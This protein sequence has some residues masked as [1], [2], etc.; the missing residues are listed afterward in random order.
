MT[1]ISRTVKGKMPQVKGALF[2]GDN[3]VLM[4]D[5]RLGKNVNIWLNCSI[6]AD[7]ASI[8]IGDN[9]NV[10]DNSVIH[11]SNC[12][13]EDYTKNPKGHVIIGKNTTIGH[14]CIIHACRIGNDCLIGMGSIIADDV[15][16]EDGALVGAGSNVTP[17]TVIKSGE[18]WFGNPAKF[19]R[20]LRYDDVEYI[21]NNASSYIE[22]AK[23]TSN[24]SEK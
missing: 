19:M 10:Q 15:L 24:N 14:S 23:S 1:F 2:I 16:I 22:M 12:E 13:D 4:G 21:K 9:S 3:T 7:F 11:V 17:R 6:R 18:L 20:N 8:I 5:V